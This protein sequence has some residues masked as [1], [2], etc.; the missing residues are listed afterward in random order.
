V[1]EEFAM[2]YDNLGGVVGLTDWAEENKTDFYKL[3]AK[4]APTPKEATFV[5][6]NN[7]L[8]NSGDVL[9]A[10]RIAEIDDPNAA[11]ATY[12]LIINGR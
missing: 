3:F 8:N 4:T 9:E 1:H 7:T 11:V 12:Q 5:Q 6:I 10:Q 2:A